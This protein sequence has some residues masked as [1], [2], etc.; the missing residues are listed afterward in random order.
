MN[1]KKATVV[2]PTT[3]ALAAG[4][5]G[6]ATYLAWTGSQLSA[7]A[8][9]HIDSLLNSDATLD[10]MAMALTAGS[11]I[12]AVWG[13]IRPLQ[14]HLIAQLG[15]V[16]EGGPRRIRKS[17]DGLLE[18]GLIWLIS[19][20]AFLLTYLLLLSF[21]DLVDIK[22]AA[23]PGNV[24]ARTG[25]LAFVQVLPDYAVAPGVFLVG[26]V[27]LVSGTWTTITSLHHLSPLLAVSEKK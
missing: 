23:E 8:T 26:I 5:N 15:G 16:S 12:V 19:F 10:L 14:E 13:M 2:V 4:V 3:F 25:L 20:S 6:L 9:A 11:L 18:A 7:E 21:D 24:F 1:T 22:N 17:I 27:L